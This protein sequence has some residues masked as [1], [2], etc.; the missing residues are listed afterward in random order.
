MVI[1][2]M[3][4]WR[5][6]LSVMWCCKG[7]FAWDEVCKPCIDWSDVIA[8]KPAPTN[9]C[10]STRRSSCTKP[11]GASLLAMVS[12]SCRRQA[13]SHKP[14][15]RRN[16]IGRRQNLCAGLPEIR[17]LRLS[18][19]S[20]ASPAPLSRVFISFSGR[21]WKARCRVLPSQQSLD[22]LLFYSGDL[23]LFLILTD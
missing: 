15:F 23:L 11:V 2:T 13:G 14:R 1:A 3:A 7:K 19:A 5:C 9:G 17:P 10:S 8:G 12:S 4:K 18:E 20:R 22:S 21:H 16:N 6:V